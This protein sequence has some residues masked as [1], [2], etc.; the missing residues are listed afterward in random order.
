MQTVKSQFQF[1]F[2]FCPGPPIS[3]PES[4]IVS[5][6]VTTLSYETHTDV[7]TQGWFKF[8]RP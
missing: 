7:T 4:G 2:F 6:V 1:C 8:T 5:R 3:Y